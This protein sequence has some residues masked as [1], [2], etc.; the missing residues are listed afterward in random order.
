M[1]FGKRLKELRIQNG[2]T[3]AQIA[4]RLG[5]RQ[6]NISDW[7]NDISRPEYENL[8][9]LSSIYDETLESLLG[10]E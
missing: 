1:E 10:L 7:E 3:Q 8:I 4:Q 6:S 2:F 9:A 5:I